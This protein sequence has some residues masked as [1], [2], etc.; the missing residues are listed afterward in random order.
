MRRV[1]KNRNDP[2]EIFTREGVLLEWRTIATT[3]N[4]DLIRDAVYKGT[5]KDAG[6]RTRSAVRDKLN[7]YYHGKCAYCEQYCKAEIEHYRPKK[8]VT[9]EPAHPG[10]YWLCYEWSNLVP[11]CRYCNTEGGKGNQFPIAGNRVTA[12][13]F[14]SDGAPDE[15][16]YSAHTAQLAGEKPLLLH[17]E[18]DDP[19]DCL[20]FDS[21]TG[22]VSMRGEDPGG[23]GAATIRICNLN[24]DDLTLSR[25]HSVFQPFKKHI[26]TIFTLVADGLMPSSNL[27]A[28]LGIVFRQLHD[29]AMNPEKEF[30]LLRKYIFSSTARFE[31]VF[32]PYIES[33]QQKELVILAFRRYKNAPL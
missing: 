24:R 25:L 19:E 21:S 13:A 16:L 7:Q 23:R 31:A 29:D 8:G 15:A 28:A 6:G 4:K 2:P 14:L 3:Q 11:S 32:A 27:P 20:G 30:T 5:Y 10:Y 1:D 22:V 18:I 33:E 9:G 12:P 17:P 26:L